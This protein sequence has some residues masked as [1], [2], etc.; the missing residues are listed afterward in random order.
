MER[1]C[2][3]CDRWA[4]S[5]CN[6][7]RSTDPLGTCPACMTPDMSVDEWRAN[8]FADAD[9]RAREANLKSTSAL[10][11]VVAPRKKVGKACLTTVWRNKSMPTMSAYGHQLEAIERFKDQDEIALFF[12]MGCGKT[13][14]SLKI[15]EHKYLQHQIYGV[16]VIA[17]NGIH[18]QWYDDLVNGVMVN[19]I[20]HQELDIDIDVQCIGGRGGQSELYPFEDNNRFKFVSV[21]IDTFST[22]HKWEAIVEWANSAKIAILIDESTVIKN[23]TAKRTERIL[24]EFN[25][26][27]RRRKTILSSVKKN[28]VRIILT[29]TPTTNGPTD[30]WCMM[31]FVKPNFFGRNY[32][33]FRSYFGMYTKLTVDTGR[34]VAIPLSEKTWQGIHACPDYMQASCTFG[35]S[36]DT[37]LTVKHQDKFQGPYKHLEELKKQLEPVSMFKKLTE[38]VDMPK[39]IYIERDVEL[40]KAQQA[41]YDN[42]KNQLLIEFDNHVATALNKLVLSIRLQQISSGFIV[43]Q[44]TILSDDDMAFV[45]T[46]A[47]FDAQDLMPN[48]VV[49]LDDKCPKIQQ[50]LSDVDEC[51]KP[52]LILTRFTAEADKIYNLLK[53]KYRTGLFTGWKI[54]G[55][56]DEFKEGNL[57][58]LV[59]NSSKI[60][61]GFN[62]QIAHTTLF[63][64]NTFSMEI[65]QQAEFR[66]FRMGQTHPCMYIDYT[67]SDIDRTINKAIAMK[68]NL[69]EYIREKNV[70]DII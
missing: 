28:P 42:M 55:G 22:Q 18:K 38:C 1:I 29:G 23:P 57:D 33:S 47:G 51:D 63:Y 65:R 3:N 21:N 20:L 32:Y 39:V 6:M 70:Q 12:E 2:K 68:K 35:C 44:K 56:I 26:V 59:A 4:D 60:A 67:A 7:N 61:R 10:K 36:E 43:G 37:Y 19:G 16:L 5:S 27:T 45:D 64:S 31:E 46:E 25:D 17:P 30:L 24:Y 50:L 14:T 9:R 41:A 49:W 52:L 58:V 69:L 53:D 11:H 8:M 62:L 15:L 54:V 34:E 13:F 66:T 48:E 40:S